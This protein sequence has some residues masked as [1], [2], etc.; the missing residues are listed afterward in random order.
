LRKQLSKDSGNKCSFCGKREGQVKKLIAGPGVYICDE[1]VDLCNEIVAEEVVG[2]ARAYVGGLRQD[3]RLES[4]KGEL[5]RLVF[6]DAD[7]W[8]ARRVSDNSVGV[9][10]L[11]GDKKLGADLEEQVLYASALEALVYDRRLIECSH[12][13]NETAYQ[14]TWQGLLQARI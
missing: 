13:D 1:C 6:K 3:D 7:K 14:L 5:L 2:G 10:V 8:I 12:A 4:A 9:Q 11:I